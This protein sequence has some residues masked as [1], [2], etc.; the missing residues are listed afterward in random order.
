MK[1]LI[2]LE[3]GKLAPLLWLFNKSLASDDFAP[4]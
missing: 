3:G 2:R 4:T 1:I